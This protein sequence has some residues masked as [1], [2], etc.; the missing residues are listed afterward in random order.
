[1]FLVAD[2]NSILV[3]RSAT[4]TYETFNIAFERELEADDGHFAATTLVVERGQRY[5]EFVTAMATRPKVVLL[6]DRWPVTLYRRWLKEHL[7]AGERPPPAVLVYNVQIDRDLKRLTNVTGIRYN[8]PAV[9]GIINLRSISPGIKR[10]GVLYR[11]I[12]EAQFQSEKKLAEREG[13]ELIG[14]PI[15]LQPSVNEI[16]VGLRAL[17]RAKVDAFWLFNDPHMLTADLL[18]EAWIPRIKQYRIPV[19]VGVDSLM[20][21]VK[22]GNLAIFPDIEGLAGQTYQ[23]M[24]DLEDNQWQ[25]GE[26]PV[27]HP[28]SVKKYFNRANWPRRMFI[29]DSILN[30]EFD[31]IIS[32]E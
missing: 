26:I 6:V 18:S 24:I 13:I 16:R 32:L 14:H 3:V 21:R 30:S 25:A 5:D 9:T 23:I 12:L 29:N 20:G 17:K 27:Q 28:L 22:L 15:P 4:T 7:P 10:V 31:A 2:P 19:I 11:P 8:I 1:M